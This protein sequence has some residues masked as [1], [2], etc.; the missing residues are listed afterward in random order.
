MSGGLGAAWARHER[1]LQALHDDALAAFGPAVADDIAVMLNQA[2]EAAATGD[3]TAHVW[4]L[5]AIRGRVRQAL[6]AQH[7]SAESCSD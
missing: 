3:D 2:R 4:A 1:A 6:E 7:D 5:L